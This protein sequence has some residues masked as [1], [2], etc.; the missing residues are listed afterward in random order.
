VRQTIIS[1][2]ART[3]CQKRT[4]GAPGNAIARSSGIATDYSVAPG[5]GFGK[6]CRW[7]VEP[8]DTSEL[9][10][11]YV[12]NTAHLVHTTRVASAWLLKSAS[13]PTVCSDSAAALLALKR[14]SHAGRGMKVRAL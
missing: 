12:D 11:R 10:R 14:D 6:E 5:V 1:T 13:A 4:A 3:C 2:L 9:N 7:A 8:V